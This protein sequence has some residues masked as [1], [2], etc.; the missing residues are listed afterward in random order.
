MGCGY[1][2]NLMEKGL[3]TESKLKCREDPKSSVGSND[4][5][6]MKSDSSSDRMCMVDNLKELNKQ[7][8]SDV[9]PK[10]SSI[11]KLK[12]ESISDHKFTLGAQ[13]KDGHDPRTSKVNSDSSTIIISTSPD[14]YTMSSSPE[15][16]DDSV[17]SIP[18]TFQN[19]SHIRNHPIVNDLYM[20]NATPY[21]PFSNG[22]IM[23]YYNGP[24]MPYCNGP[25][26]P[27]D[28]NVIMTLGNGPVM[29]D[30][31]CTCMLNTNGLYMPNANVPYMSN[32]NC[33]CMAKYQ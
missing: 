3:F 10:V 30:V 28:N 31:N 1:P 24:I 26:L 13:H 14:I 25:V 4:L 9:S 12:T 6:T 23:P 15:N 5:I 7:S 17:S 29:P 8:S 33:L 20:P 27:F 32:E 22:S 2:L 16:E 11:L 18:Q 21:M 19:Y